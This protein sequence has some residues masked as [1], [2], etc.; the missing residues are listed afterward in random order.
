MKTKTIIMLL[1]ALVIVGAQVIEAQ[2]NGNGG[3]YGKRNRGYNDMF[4]SLLYQLPEQSIESWEAENLSHLIEE[5]KL[6]RDVYLTLGAKWDL[7]IFTNIAESEGRHMQAVL[8][9]I[10]KYDLPS[11]VQ[12]DEIGAFTNVKFQELY[13]VLVDRGSQSLLDALIVGATIEDMDIADIQ[14]MLAKTDNEDMQI[15]FQNLMRGSRNHIRSFYSN[16]L[17][18]GG[19]YEPKYITIE[20][21][22]SIINS[23]IERGFSNGNG[24]HYYGNQGW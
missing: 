9:L 18:Y 11:P 15:L 10:A 5:E 22:E 7:P 4:N 1:M 13:T 20:E 17:L 6:A 14:E 3:R 24:G 19:T 16:V 12:S 21:F 23:D 2:Q 8:T